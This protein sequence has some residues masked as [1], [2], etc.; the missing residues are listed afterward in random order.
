MVR[1]NL[2]IA[3]TLMA[4]VAIIEIASAQQSRRS[5]IMKLAGAELWVYE[6]RD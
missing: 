2:T 1:K 5:D 6:T 4:G 3:L